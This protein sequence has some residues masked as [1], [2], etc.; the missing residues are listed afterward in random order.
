MVYGLKYTRTFKKQIDRAK[1]KDKAL[2]EELVKKVRKL[3]E[4][5]YSGKPLKHRL[6]QYRSLRVKG[7]Y[8]VTTQVPK[9]LSGDFTMQ[10]LSGTWSILQPTGNLTA[11][12]AERRRGGING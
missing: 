2:V 12:Y 8:R 9:P 6:S 1:K 4:S 5:P 10:E 11:E 3:Q 7:K